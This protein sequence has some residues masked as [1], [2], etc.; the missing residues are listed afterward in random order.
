[1]T[2]GE[3]IKYWRKKRGLTQDELA[4]KTGLANKQVISGIESGKRK[5]SFNTLEKIA[6]ALI[7]KVDVLLKDSL[8]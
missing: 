6:D 1:M 4:E 8:K 2:I 3:Q 7:C 5:P